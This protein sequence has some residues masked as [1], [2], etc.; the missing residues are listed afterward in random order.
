[1]SEAIEMSLKP[2]PVTERL[3]NCGSEVIALA[4]WERGP[5]YWVKAFGQATYTDSCGW[6]S[7]L[8]LH[9]MIVTHWFPMP[10]KPE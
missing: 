6:D 9:G 8:T 5:N 4:E 1:M 10:P 3:P 7:P 2:I